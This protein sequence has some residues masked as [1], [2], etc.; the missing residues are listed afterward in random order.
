LNRIWAFKSNEKDAVLTY[1]IPLEFTRNT[2][3]YL[4]GVGQRRR[5][6]L[7]EAM[8]SVEARR[9]WMQPDPLA[10]APRK[11]IANAAKRFSKVRHWLHP[12]SRIADGRAAHRPLHAKMLAVAYRFGSDEATLILIGSPNMS[13]RALLLQSGTGLGNVEVGLAFSIE[14]R[15]ELRDF[16]PDLVHAPASMCTPTERDFPEKDRNFA[17]AIDEASHDPGAKALRVL[18]AP[19]ASDLPPWRLSYDG[20][21]IASS[22]EP[23]SATVHVDDFTLTPSTAEVMLHVNGKE[24]SA[25]ILVTDLV[26]L[27][28]TVSGAGVGLNEL[29]MLLSRR[30][31]TERTLLIAERRNSK[32]DNGLTSLFGE[33]FSPTDVF[34][35]WWCAAEDLAVADLS[36]QAFRLRLEGALGIGAAWSCMLEAV[37]QS[38]MTREEAWFF[39]AELLRSL[40]EFNLPQSRELDAKLRMMVAF[41]ARVRSD[42][43]AIRLSAETRPWKDLVLRFYGKTMA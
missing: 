30:I 22:V 2:M 17:L 33:S 37:E 20:R 36:V 10:F 15:L 11:A 23:P 27:P 8:V 1:R 16:V 28:V 35:A 40:S 6:P 34:K 31:G 14:G 12:A 43:E 21:D 5:M 19:S 18:W 9:F 32:S 25:P 13:R 39:G 26:G 41:K 38:T 4:D 3:F 7:D 29:L 42:L 24:Y